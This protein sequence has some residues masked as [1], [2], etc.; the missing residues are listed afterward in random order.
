MVWKWC[1]QLKTS[2]VVGNFLPEISSRQ[3]PDL[4]EHFQVMSS[5]HK[6]IIHHEF[7]C[8]LDLFLHISKDSLSLF[9]S[10]AIHIST[11]HT[12]LSFHFPLKKDIHTV[13]SLSGQAAMICADF[14]FLER[15]ECAKALKKDILTGQA[16]LTCADFIFLECS[17]CAKA[18][19]KD[20][21]TV[22][23]SNGQAALTCADFIFLE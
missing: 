15:G 23:S 13:P 5:A 19:K 16:A 6:Y 9:C 21:H 12:S 11:A 8:Y 17:E 4:R 18:L 3:N 20:I 10:I 2:H 14:I 7:S 22:P 1:L